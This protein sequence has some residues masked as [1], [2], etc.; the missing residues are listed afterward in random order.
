MSRGTVVRFIIED[1]ASACYA[2]IS[3]TTVWGFNDDDYNH[4]MYVSFGKINDI[5]ASD[6]LLHISCFTLEL[7]ESYDKKNSYNIPENVVTMTF[8]AYANKDWTA[9]NKKYLKG[10][11]RAIDKNEQY[12]GDSICFEAHIDWDWERRSDPNQYMIELCKDVDG[13]K[14]TYFDSLYS[15]IRKS[16]QGSKLNHRMEVKLIF[17]DA[18][19]IKPFNDTSRM[20]IWVKKNK[21]S[22]NE[23]DN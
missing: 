17:T 6:K 16:Y 4:P 15:I 9:I 2:T 1:L 22:E 19:Y 5:E 21:E 23:R 12:F 10:E 13:E 11:I 8:K 14:G 20:R 18:K 3:V 7:Y